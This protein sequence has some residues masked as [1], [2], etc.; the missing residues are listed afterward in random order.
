MT[1]ISLEEILATITE[2]EIQAQSGHNDGWVVGAYEKNLR[3]LRER[4][5]VNKEPRVIT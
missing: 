1:D 2:W 4:L 5:E 3:K